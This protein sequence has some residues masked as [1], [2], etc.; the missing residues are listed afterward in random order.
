MSRPYHV[1]FVIIREVEVDADDDLQAEREAFQQLPIDDQGA[2]VA[3]R[4]LNRSD[5]LGDDDLGE[6]GLGGALAF[7]D[8]SKN[9]RFARDH[10]D[11]LDSEWVSA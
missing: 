1:Q 11:A 6:A 3:L 7:D 5:E 9:W 8:R 4:V 2:A 10:F